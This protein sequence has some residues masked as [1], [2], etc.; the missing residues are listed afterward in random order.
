MTPS[1]FE[2]PAGDDEKNEGGKNWK[3]LWQSWKEPLALFILAVGAV[4][5]PAYLIGWLSA[6]GQTMGTA[7]LLLLIAGLLVYF[8]FKPLGNAAAGGG[9][10]MQAAIVDASANPASALVV[11]LALWGLC[12]SWI[13]GFVEGK[14]PRASELPSVS[15]VLAA[16]PPG[17]D[18]AKA[19]LK[20]R[21]A[22]L[23][24][25]MQ[26][27]G[28]SSAEFVEFVD[29]VVVPLIKSGEQAEAERHIDWLTGSLAR[30]EFSAPRG[31]GNVQQ[32]APTGV[33]FGGPVGSAAPPTQ[34]PASQ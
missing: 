12:L 3:A 19:S 6:N 8:G 28:R 22:W 33:I 7:T 34:L 20:A 29:D 24:I 26:L 11:T 4:P 9:P 2:L 17:T 10:I 18:P 30:A 21:L 16:V 32:P 1:T 13:Y 15:S 27:K 25:T 23:R 31:M 5:A 14:H